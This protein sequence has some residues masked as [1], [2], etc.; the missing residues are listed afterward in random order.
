L[1]VE[2]RTARAS[3]AREA[4]DAGAIDRIARAMVEISTD[5]QPGETA[6][7]FY[8]AGAAP[9]ARRLAR[10]A[11]ERGARV[12]Y[13]QRDQRLEAEVAATCSPRDAL[14]SSVLNDL[15]IQ[16]SDAVLIARC[17]TDAEAFESVPHERMKLWNQARETYLTD[18]RVSHTRWVLTYWPTEQ[19]AAIEGMSHDEY[20]RLY[21]RAC[22][23]PWREIHAAQARLVELLN[24]ATT[25]ELEARPGDPDPARRTRLRM[26]IGPMRFVNSTIDRN[27]PGAEVFA[28][29]VR[30]TVDG[31]LFAAGRHAY[32]GRTIEDIFLRAERGRIVEAHARVGERELIEIL[33]TDDGARYF[34]EVALGTNPG[35]RRQVMNGLLNEK[36]G[37]SFHIT[38]GRAYTF[39][40]YEG[41]AVVVDNGNRS[42]VHWDIAVPMLPAYGGGAVR[43]DGREIQRDG[44]FLDPALAVLNAGLEGV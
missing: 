18:Y 44:R 5:V 19:E 24:A 42:Q 25:L 30:E 23:Q 2:R 41:Q 27:F 28:A 40:E 20:V 8:D 38:P 21:L 35:L 11:S 43:L 6:L 26:G 4:L 33:D 13:L 32:D 1:G 34:G 22:D 16:T 10:I 3:G 9:L 12:L 14:R 7:V 39:S 15:A 29:P 17:A 36:V 31:Q 37:G